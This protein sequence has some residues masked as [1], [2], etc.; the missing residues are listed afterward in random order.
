MRKEVGIS[1]MAVVFIFA[2]IILISAAPALVLHPSSGSSATI[3]VGIGFT[4]GAN[5][6]TFLDGGL[7]PSVPNPLVVSGSG[8]FAAII[9][10]PPQASVG[11]HVIT[12]NDGT[13]QSS[14]N[15]N[16]INMTGPPG[17]Q[18]VQGVKGD[19]GDQGIQGI[20]GIQG[21][22]GQPGVAAEQPE[23]NSTLLILSMS[24]AV[25]SLAL[26]IIALISALKKKK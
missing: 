13:L 2:N 10:I 17:S 6:A 4:P 9:T 7:V 26:A 5:V 15:F 8:G 22:K 20:Q 18:G 23:N 25:I 14:S 1:L 12:A 21:E 3:I 11:N 19:K 16:V 24:V